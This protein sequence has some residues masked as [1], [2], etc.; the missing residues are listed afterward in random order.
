M[1]IA[2][3]R[4]SAV[5]KEGGVVTFRTYIDAKKVYSSGRIVSRKPIIGAVV[6]INKLCMVGLDKLQFKRDVVPTSDSSASIFPVSHS[7]SYFICLQ[8]GRLSTVVC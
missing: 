4:I 1:P 5:K 6:L 3:S 7:C 8:Y 2:C